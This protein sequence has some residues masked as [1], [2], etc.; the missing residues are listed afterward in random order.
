MSIQVI[1]FAGILLLILAA[2]IFLWPK[3]R[4]PVLKQERP[5]L[6]SEEYADELT[7]PV[8]PVKITRYQEPIPEPPCNYGNDRLVLMVKDPNWLYAYWEI[9]PAKKE[10][11]C[12]QYGSLAWL[13]APLLLRVFD[14][15]GID[16][17]GENACSYLDIQ[18]MEETGN[19]Y[20]N[21]GQPN[22]NFILDLG[23]RL[24]D[25]RFI[26]LLRSN[27]VMTPRSCM[28]DQMDDEEW[29]WIEG[30]DY[31]IGR[32]YCSL[33]SAL[34]AEEYQLPL[35]ATSPVYQNPEQYQ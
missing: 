16:F 25:G 17:N 3:I 27:M 26:T 30:I 12:K 20:I 9:S 15:T 29:M 33:S 24:P 7:L 34:I 8:K 10:D 19:W 28:S 31:Y 1:W 6:Y 21:I 5:V 14:I 32:T 2:V 13:S 35:N 23:K 22:R 4:K 18:I 11:F